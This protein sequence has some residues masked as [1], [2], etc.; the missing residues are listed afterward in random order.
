MSAAIAEQSITQF[1]ATHHSIVKRC[2]STSIRFHSYVRSVHNEQIHKCW[3][4]SMNGCEGDAIT[5]VE[6]IQT[7]RF[8]S[9]ATPEV[10]MD[11]LISAISELNCQP[12][13]FSSGII[14]I[15]VHID[16]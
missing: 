10:A 15:E 1:T 2:F 5:P 16:G 3:S 9:V 6:T 11:H 13:G 14:R 7:R 12:P 8:S 4:L